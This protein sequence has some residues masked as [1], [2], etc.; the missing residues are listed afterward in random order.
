M[1]KIRYD[2]EGDIPEAMKEH[3]AADEDGFVL[4]A[5][6]LRTDDDVSNV[7]NALDKERR[8]KREAERKLKD[9][10][11][12]LPEDFSIDEWN[13]LKDGGEG[14]SDQRLAEQRERLQ[15]Q[16]QKREAKLTEQ[17]EA[18]SANVHR[19]LARNG[20]HEAMAQAEIAEPFRPAVEAMFLP[21]VS[22]EGDGGDQVALI[23]DQSLPEAMK[24]FAESDQ[25]RHYVAA[26]HNSGGGTNGTRNG[27]HERKWS[28]MSEAEHV[29]LYRKSPDEYRRLRDQAA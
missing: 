25:G 4:Q 2:N 14:E 20:L 19:L 21:Q 8:A 11:D 28:D 18:A 10:Q 1:L 17:L 15:T 3:Y 23:K 26:R 9:V 5:E 22:I 12:D 13:R 7:K 16:A 6:G 24:A 27:S 29:E